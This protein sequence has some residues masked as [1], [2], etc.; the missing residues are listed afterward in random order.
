M[1]KLIMS[2]TLYRLSFTKWK[3][4]ERLNQNIERYNNPE[5]FDYN[6]KLDALTF[7]A[8]GKNI[9]WAYTFELLHSEAVVKLVRC[10]YSNKHPLENWEHQK[11][12]DEF[13]QLHAEWFEKNLIQ[14]LQEGGFLG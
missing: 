5:F 8:Y 12:T 3:P 10:W 11:A 9:L 2:K 4:A 1:E 7:F 14:E 13:P 6:P